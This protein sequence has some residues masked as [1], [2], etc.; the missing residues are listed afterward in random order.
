MQGRTNTSAAW[1][2]V[3][4]PVQHGL[5]NLLTELVNAGVSGTMHQPC[6]TRMLSWVVITP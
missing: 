5:R 6:L 4:A 3:W 2:R 1:R